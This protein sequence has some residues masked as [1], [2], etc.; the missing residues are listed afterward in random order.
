MP[1]IVSAPF[2]RAA[3]GFCSGAIYETAS[4]TGRPR[5]SSLP[6]VDHGLRLAPERPAGEAEADA[7]QLRL[8][9]PAV[10]R[11]PLAAAVGAGGLR[12]AVTRLERLPPTVRGDHGH[13]DDSVVP[14]LDVEVPGL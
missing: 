12:V 3:S 9:L 10:E 5:Y 4:K 13:A 2:I 11:R 6:S 1:G 14:H 7:H 8:A